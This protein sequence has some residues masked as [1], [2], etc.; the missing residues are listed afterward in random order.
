MNLNLSGNTQSNINSTQVVTTST[1]NA[2]ASTGAQGSSA[3]LQALSFA[4]GQVFSGEVAEISGKEILI[5]LANNQTITAKMDGDISLMLGQSVYFEVKSNNNQQVYLR[6]LYTNLMSA[7]PAVIKALDAANLPVNE[8]TVAMT[9]TMMEEGMPINKNALQSMF[10]QLS[11]NQE[12][13][14]K[15]LVQMT[16][17]ELPITSSNIEQFANYKSF[18]HQ[19]GKDLK[20]LMERLPEVTSDLSAQG[21]PEKAVAFGKELLYLLASQNERNATNLPEESSISPDT[22]D[23]MAGQDKESIL[24]QLRSGTGSENLLKELPIEEREKLAEKLESLGMPQDSKTQVISGQMTSHQLIDIVKQLF[25]QSDASQDKSLLELMKNDGFQSV[26]KDELQQLWFLKPEEV[27]QNG[28]VDELY[29]RLSAQTQKLVQIMQDAGKVDT[30]LMKSAVN[31]QD[32]VNFM[33][34]LNQVLTYVQLPLKMHQENAHG[35]LYVYTNKKDLM[36][37]KDGNVSALLHLDMENLGEMDIYVAMQ[38]NKVNTHFYLQKE[39]VLDLIEDNLHI[40]NERLNKK[41]YQM[42]TVVSKKESNVKKNIVEEFLHGKG[43]ETVPSSSVLK[44]SFDV[45]A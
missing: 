13:D 14:P 12:T 33:N 7:D 36:N 10:R 39:E 21:N 29:Q 38:K 20:I 8:R 30:T 27:S 23:A 1:T 11:V 32:S 42:S 2:I 26:L 22:M 18:E 28:K 5:L 19:I 37:S 40:L 25:V 16:K 35:E 15:M 24:N 3:N 9:S 41:G 44:Y 45:R 31:M 4:V 43:E 34:Q 17:L 6:P